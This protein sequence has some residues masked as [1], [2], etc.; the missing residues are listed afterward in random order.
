TSATIS[1]VDSMHMLGSD[2]SR[3]RL[4]HAIELL[5]GIPKKRLKDV[6]KAY[7]ALAAPRAAGSA[8]SEGG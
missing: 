7:A 5:G 8:V 6:E 1:V 4:R 2:L 3:A